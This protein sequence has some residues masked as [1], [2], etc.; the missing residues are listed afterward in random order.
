MDIPEKII[1]GML[2]LAIGDALGAP[3]EGF[4]PG[5]ISSVFGKVDNY[6]DSRKFL[7]NKPYLWRLPGFYTDDTQQALVIIDTIL[8]NNDFRTKKASELFIRLSEGEFNGYFGVYRGVGPNFRKSVDL[9]KNGTDWRESGLDTAGNGA[10]MR[11]APMAFHYYNNMHQLLVN[12]IE[13]SL[14]THKNPI[15]ILSACCISFLTAYFINN[16]SI[17]P[18]SLKDRLIKFLLNCESELIKNYKDYLIPGYEKY[19]TIV[20][21]TIEKIFDII[22]EPVERIIKLIVANA[23]EY[24]DYNIK[25]PTVGFALCSVIFSIVIVLKNLNSFHDSIF[26]A[27]NSGGDTDTIGA[28]V[29]AMAGSFNGYSSIPEKWVNGLANNSQIKIRAE[30]L[31]GISDTKIKNLYE[32]EREL[33]KKEYNDREALIKKVEPVVKIKK[34]V[35]KPEIIPGFIMPSESGPD[36]YKIKQDKAKWRDYQKKKSKNKKMRRSNKKK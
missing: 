28:M 8:S 14:V 20:R 35:V 27:V 31:A 32:M 36:I 34:A 29:G 6:V 15:G 26:Y 9:L 1:G 22:S 17:V 4:K 3:V 12:S 10:A 16:D 11:I 5:S 25:R 33:T 18:D 30:K 23:A 7:K 13:I 24:T 19:M 2:G 21:K